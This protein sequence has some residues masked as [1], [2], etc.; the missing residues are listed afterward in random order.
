MKI[1]CGIIGLPNVGKSSLFNWL[2]NQNVRSENYP[3]CT[4]E[5]NVG[6]SSVPDNRQKNI[7]NIV[8]TKN[9]IPAQVKFIDIAG[10]IKGASLGEG[11]G[12]KFLSNIRD[13]Q[14]IIHVVRCFEDKKIISSLKK[15]IDVITTLDIINTELL[16]A[17][18]E[19]IKNRIDNK[20][21]RF[22]YTKQEKMFFK[23]LLEHVSS[24][25]N[26][27]NFDGIK[28]YYKLT[29]DMGLLTLKPIIYVVNVDKH[30]DKLI[31]ENIKKY[32]KSDN[33]PVIALDV[34]NKDNIDML[35]IIIKETYKMLD[36]ITF[37]SVG[38]KEI[39]AW[40]IKNN[41]S[42]LEAANKIHSDIK[43]GFIKAEVVS[44]DDYIKYKDEN[45]M[46]SLGKYR[47]E[48]KKYIVQ[49]GDIINFRFNI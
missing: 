43:K 48:G 19:I 37:F 14:A 21:K 29:K 24:G 8:K 1:S 47:K 9:I 36:M 44:Y 5:P 42:A 26:I 17:D 25:F 33:S 40:S 11:L 46:K 18:I 6:I 30:Y 49:D 12:N 45:L 20:K 2:T 38:K 23:N 15:E 35:N 32:V 41:S 31:L 13:T 34:K 7:N 10:L 16:L 28:K 39:R 4:I 22:V 27:R 3:F